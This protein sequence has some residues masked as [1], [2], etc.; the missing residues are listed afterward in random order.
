MHELAIAAAGDVELILGQG[1]VF[2]NRLDLVFSDLLL[3][4]FTTINP[5][6]KSS[7]HTRIDCGVLVADIAG[8]KALVNPMI[9]QTD[10]IV[11]TSKGVIDLDSEQVDLSFNTRPRTGIGI[12]PGMVIN[13][14]LKLGGTLA[15]P[16]MSLDASSAAITGGAAVVTSGLS[17]LGKSLF[18]RYLRESDPCGKVV[19]ELRRMHASDKPEAGQGQLP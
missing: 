7:P 16:S 6:A 14:F 17:L 12:S 10:K 8:G 5:F 11:A 9:I 4:L 19:A 1:Q 13:P 3:E 15:Q 18:D 2:N